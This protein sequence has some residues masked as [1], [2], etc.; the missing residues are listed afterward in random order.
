[1]VSAACF[2]VRVSVMFLLMF[3]YYTFSSGWMVSGHFLGNSYPLGWPFVLIVFCLFVIFIH[4]PL[5]FWE[6]DM[7]FDLSSSCS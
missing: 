6:W 1:M 2:G 5:W 4:F 7:A 3:V